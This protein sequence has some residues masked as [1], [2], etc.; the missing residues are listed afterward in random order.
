MEKN[1]LK[2]NLLEKLSPFFKDLNF[3]LNKSVCE[4]TERCRWGWNKFHLIFLDRQYGWEINLGMLIRY[5]FVEDI[6]HKAS[7]YE[8][9]YHKTT[10]TIGISIEKFINDGKD[11][12]CYLNSEDDIDICVNYIKT[13]FIKIAVPF[14][15]KYDNLENLEE[16]INIEN[17]ASLFSG[18]K[19]EGNVGLILAKIVQNPNYDLLLEKY[20][21]Y[22]E[23]LND[24]FY[25]PEFKMLVKVLDSSSFTNKS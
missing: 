14:Y 19:Y 21:K 13:L 18:L 11:Y 8:A 23:N 24:G 6:Y 4:F 2:I 20:H 17:G 3:S 22:Y 15:E 5:H 7:Y 16:A 10:P 12:R 1:K 25:L 9:K